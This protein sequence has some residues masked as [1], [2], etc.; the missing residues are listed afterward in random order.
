MDDDIR[1][2]GASGPFPKFAPFCGTLF[3]EL[4][5]PQIGGTSSFPVH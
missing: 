2:R 1:K 3:C 4:Y 5:E